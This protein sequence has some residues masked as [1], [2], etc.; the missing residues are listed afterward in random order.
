V[1]GVDGARWRRCLAV[2]PSDWGLAAGLHPWRA[3]SLDEA[4]LAAELEDLA[5]RARHRRCCALGE[6]GLDR[7]R[8]GDAEGWRRQIRAFE[9]HCALAQDR[10]LPLVLHC[11]RA[12][13]ELRAVLRAARGL[14]GVVHGFAAGPQEAEAYLALGL[15]LGFGPALTRRPSPRLLEAARRCP[16]A[17]LLVETDA[18]DRPVAAAAGRPGEP[19]DLTWVLA[20]LAAA[21]GE[22]CAALAQRCGANARTLFPLAEWG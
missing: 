17:R 4:A 8:G 5:Q 6:T 2:A 14:A 1:A 18:P 7:A 16:P 15:S 21:R 20:A 11:V 13:S 3:A 19:A 9:A 22:P 12:H 10:A